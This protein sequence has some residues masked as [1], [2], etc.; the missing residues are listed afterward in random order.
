MGEAAL[1]LLMASVNLWRSFLVARR[2]CETGNLLDDG[3]VVVTTTTTIAI[4]AKQGEADG[5]GRVRGS[6]VLGEGAHGYG[7]GCLGD[8]VAW[9]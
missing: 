7:V 4:N 1:L 9:V 5:G 6:D 3:L 2:D 8:D